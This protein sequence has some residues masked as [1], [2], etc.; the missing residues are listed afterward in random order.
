VLAAA[1]IA[2]PEA[3]A[4]G[5]PPPVLPGTSAVAQY[6]ESLPSSGGPVGAGGSSAAGENAGK[7]ALPRSVVAQVQARAG[8]DAG[9]LLSLAATG[10]QA[11]GGAGR[12]GGQTRSRT[13]K[14]AAPQPPEAAAKQ[15][16]DAS[17]AGAAARSVGRGAWPLV[18]ALVLV[19]CAALA[20][21]YLARR[22]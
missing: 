20:A 6:V 10:T 2:S 11:L 1:A 3:L 13:A 18:L 14:S 15:P 7:A 12:P 5:A 17:A 22:S 21:G 8:S 19:S 16:Q 4:A 9:P